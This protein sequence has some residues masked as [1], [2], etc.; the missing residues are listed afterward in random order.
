[1]PY[2]SGGVAFGTVKV[3]TPTGSDRDTSTRWTL[4]ASVEYAFYDNWLAKLE[5]LYL[6][7]GSATCSAATCGLATDANVNFTANIVRAGLNYRF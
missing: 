2:I 4:G 1:M 3:S 5:Y 7:L 6:D